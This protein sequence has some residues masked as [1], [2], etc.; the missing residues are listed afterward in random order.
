MCYH[1]GNLIQLFKLNFSTTNGKTVERQR[2]KAKG[3]VKWQPVTEREVFCFPKSNWTTVTFFYLVFEGWWSI[4]KLNM[5]TTID[6]YGFTAFAIKSRLKDGNCT[7]E[8]WW[9]T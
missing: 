8:A 2:R 5:K 3:P 7:S 6:G 1:E 9:Q 4:H